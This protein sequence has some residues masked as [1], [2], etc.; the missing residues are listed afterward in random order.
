MKKEIAKIIAPMSDEAI[1]EGAI[2]E[3][4]ELISALA[5]R[6][7]ILRG[8]NPTPKNALRNFE[9]IKEEF[10]DCRVMLDALDIRFELSDEK[11]YGAKIERWQ[12][13]ME[14]RI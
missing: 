6:L 3:C 10:G 8:E 1:I 5:K 7:R 11:M 2:E 13:R 9:E 4:S 12:D 14:H